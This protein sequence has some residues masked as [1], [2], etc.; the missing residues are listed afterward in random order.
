MHTSLTT[1]KDQ[2]AASLRTNATRLE[3]FSDAVFAFS[4]TLLVVSLE[5]PDNFPQLITE[6]QGFIAFGIRF[7]VLITLW[8][9][10]HAFFRRF[11]IADGM[12]VFL[13]AC[14]LFVILFYVYPMKFLT[15]AIVSPFIRG[16]TPGLGMSGYQD[17]SLMFTLYSL[18]F[19]AIFLCVVL[20][21]RHVYRKHRALNL[22]SS[23]KREALFYTRHYGIFI[24]VGMLSILLSLL[25]IGIQIGLPGFV[26][27]IL[28]PLCYG[29]AI[30][31]NKQNIS[32]AHTESG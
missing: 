17:L 25:Q 26:Y 18:G 31:H 3:A 22:S 2:Q 7:G 23:Q 28:G 32:L 1:D 21:Y 6:L 20:M 9:V 8:T 11:Q 16:T 4:A 30:W 15:E 29:H 14:L 27:M 19:V 13:N 24:G 10:H 12:T 5:V